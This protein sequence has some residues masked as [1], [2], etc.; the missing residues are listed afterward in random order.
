MSGVPGPPPRPQSAR[1]G[2]PQDT[3]GPCTGQAQAEGLK[4]NVRSGLGLCKQGLEMTPLPH[5]SIAVFL[6]GESGDWH[7][8]ASPFLS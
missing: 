5:H 6:P 2:V 4:Q 3:L 7:C 1:R 8:L